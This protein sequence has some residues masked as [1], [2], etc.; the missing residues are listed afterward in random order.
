M[1]QQ[2]HVGLMPLADEE[3]ARGK[4]AYKM[5]Q[6]MSCGAAVVVSPVGMNQRV[7]D[8]ADVGYAA[9]DLDSWVD[10]LVT[11]ARD[12]DEA[13]RLGV[14][15]R[16]LVEQKYSGTVVVQQLAKIFQDAAST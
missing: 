4:C 7:L 1:V 6:Y 3:W 5:L 13:H 9:T 12:P 14:N 16:A 8:E 15:G 2:M 11:L 10:A